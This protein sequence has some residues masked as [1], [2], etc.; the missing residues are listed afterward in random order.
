[1]T[2]TD[3]LETDAEIGQPGGVKL[4]VIAD[5]LPALV[6]Y[7]DR[8]MTYRYVNKTFV[9]WSGKPRDEI[10]GHRIGEV[11]GEAYLDHIRPHIAKTL[12]GKVSSYEGKLVQPGGRVVQ[13]RVTLFPYREQ[14]GTVQGYFVL[15]SD[16]TDT[17]DTEEK[18]ERAERRLI[19]AIESLSDGFVIFDA[20]GRL[21]LCNSTYRRLGAGGESLIKPGVNYREIV[22]ANIRAGFH[23]KAAGREDEYIEEFIK[24]R[25]ESGQDR[26]LE[27]APGRWVLL[28]DRRTENGDLVSIRTDI[29]HMRQREDR[30]RMLSA[31]VEFSPAAILVCD[32]KGFIE[33]INPRF[34]AIFGFAPE[35]LIGKHVRSLRCDQTPTE[36]YEDLERTVVAG[37]E[38][39]AE[40]IARRKDG[41]L[42]WSKLTAAPVMSPEGKVVNI[43][44]ISEDISEAKARE[45]RLR[46]LSAAVESS[47]SAVFLISADGIVEYVNPKFESLFGYSSAE[48]VGRHMSIFRSGRTP[49]R[50]Y[51]ELWE[52]ISSGRVWQGEVSTKRKDGSAFCERLTAAPV[53][54]ED[55]EI[56]NYL[57]INEDIS[58]AKERE[59]ELR[60]LS[61]AVEQSPASVFITDPRGRIEY[62]NAAFARQTGYRPE[63]VIGKRIDILR[64]SDGPQDSYR[65]IGDAIASGREWRGEV[66]TLRKDG[67]VFE[68][69]TTVAP[70]RSESG[71]ILN[72]LCFNEDIAE[73]KHRENQLR[74]SEE[75]FR[76]IYQHAETGLTIVDTNGR[77][78]DANPAY[79]R[80]LGYT[81]DEV[82][83]LTVDDL[84]HPDD[85][86]NTITDFENIRTGRDLVLGIDHSRSLEKRL[87]RKDGSLVWV[88][89]T[90]SVVR[91]DR[92]RM[93]YLIGQH[94][95]ITPLKEA[96]EAQAKSQKQLATITANL[97]EAVLVLDVAGN[98]QFCNPA[99]REL[100]RVPDEE[101][102]VGRHVDSLL[103]TWSGVKLVTF[104]GSPMKQSIATGEIIRND[105][106]VIR[107]WDDDDLEVAFASAP[108]SDEQ[109][110][111]GCVLSFR[112]IK[113]FKAAQRETLQALKLASVGEL[114]A[115]I[116]HEINTPSQYI[117]D[118]LC[119]VRD[120]FSGIATALSE[121]RQIVEEC[122]ALGPGNPLIE[123]FDRV[124][125][126]F[127]LDFLLSEIPLAAEQSLSGIEQISR[128]VLAMKEFSHPG[129]KEKVPVDINQ[130]LNSTITV[131]RNEW[132]HIAEL[133]ADLDP[134]LPLVPCVS[135][136]IN[137]V[138][139]NL[140][141]N[142]THAIEDKQDK[143]RG[144]IKVS[145]AKVGDF[146]EIQIADDGK[147][148]PEEIRNKIFDP[149]FT[150]KEV[151][152]GSGQ[153]LAICHDVVVNKHGGT[154]TFQSRVGVGT[155][156]KVRL[157]ITMTNRPPE[158]AR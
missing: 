82:K 63:E 1:M 140:I 148:M 131:C 19:D 139:L 116:A 138:F 147:G 151:G 78:V 93:L 28:R 58:E 15:G 52:T 126:E 3:V 68:E 70:V 20:E 76:G 32:G 34:Q 13:V 152:R 48:I 155:T 57:S 156:F 22:R 158:N 36:I 38:W 127:D 107:I 16:I 124:V 122:R 150:T 60:R 96:E 153:G 47:P 21:V 118:N 128:I 144:L 103:T 62:V 64:S 11:L 79:C 39:Q 91:D 8:D 104:D 41:S 137:Q 35:H 54:S 17:R 117:G 59:G 7:V 77:F 2:A 40:V 37:K 69:R 130:A 44:S 108:L 136:E 51:R 129:A 53:F 56:I 125:S 149:F 5:S 87:I 4:E 92:G 46:M 89:L 154:I 98:I 33:Y 80:L 75:R 45:A 110:I 109:V 111:S 65:E 135:G 146:V 25:Y 49:D 73:L 23:P 143:E 88:L 55:G 102:P 67:S 10:I 81:L 18:V 157:P 31:A 105:D 42:F 29:S 133:K 12:A 101:D 83:Q 123:K 94:Q 119:F 112:D 90:R 6:A 27:I 132:K 86:Q 85:R 71:D 99:A 120:S 14:G 66:K 72:Y 145:T 113:R 74:V 9:R 24:D 26:E 43:L 141:V 134:T 30:L 142:A 115:G 106:A 97:F 121:I 84:I 61:M 50:V 114:A 95:D 100:L